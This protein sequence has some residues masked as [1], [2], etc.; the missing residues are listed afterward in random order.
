MKW[1]LANVALHAL[2]LGVIAF[3]LCGWIWP[4]TRPLHLVLC[5]LTAFSWFILGPLLGKPGHCF[6]TGF[7][8]RVWANLGQSQQPNYMSY[9]FQRVSGRAPNVVAIDRATQVAF[10]T[11]M[12]LSIWM[13]T[14]SG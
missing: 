14:R 13:F 10:Y 5:A 12:L 9:L 11:C 3:C 7:Q 8:H 4:Q 2:H 1:R 6:L